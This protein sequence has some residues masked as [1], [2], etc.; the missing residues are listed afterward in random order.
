MLA[1]TAKR[2]EA[3]RSSRTSSVENGA[4]GGPAGGGDAPQPPAGDGRPDCPRCGGVGWLRRDLPLGHADFGR[5]FPCDCIQ[6]DLAERRLAGARRASNMAALGRMT[7]DSFQIT[8]PGNTAQAMGS[9]KLAHDATLAFAGRPEGWLVLSGGYGSGKTHLAAAIVNQRLA[10]GESA[11]FVVVPDL[12]D[13]LRA[14]YAPGAAEA[15]DERFDAVRS[16]PL[17]VL[18]D[19]GAEASSPWAAEKLFQLLNFRYNGRLPTVFTTNQPLEDLDERLRSRLGEMGFVRTVELRALDYRGG[20]HGDRSN[21]SSLGLYGDCRFQTWDPR[22]GELSPEGRENLQRAFQAARDF[23]AEPQGWLVL[24][25]GPGCGKTHLAAAVANH[26]VTAGGMAMF[27]VAPDLLDY[28]RAAFNPQSR[29]SYDKRFE[30]VRSTPLLV[31]DDLGTENATP[32]AKEKLFQILN[33]RYA[34]RLPTVITIGGRGADPWKRIDERLV[35]RINDRR[36]C[37][38]L[39]IEAPPY[40]GPVEA[41]RK[42]APGRR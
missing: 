8:A 13:H 26:W 12:L 18:D 36:R 3:I 31:L 42:K 1:E 23:A 27:V 38:V 40:G 29:G 34:A 39:E 14:A 33:H 20:L 16:A 15:Y 17:L 24:Q 10:D 30:E 6:A 22:A 25:G 2:A 5:A 41:P 32:W 4:G 21:L 9:L 19:L 7:F 11:L 28:L 35:S 37:R